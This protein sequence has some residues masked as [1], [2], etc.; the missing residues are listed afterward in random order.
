MWKDNSV[1]YVYLKR[2][3]Y[4]FSRRVPKDLKRYYKQSKITLSLRTK[5]LKVAKAKSASLATRLD[6]D[7]LTLR[8]RNNDNPLKRYMSENSNSSHEPSSA[9]LISKAKD[10]YVTAKG[11]SRPLTFAQ[12]VDRAISNLERRMKRISM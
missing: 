8:W 10:I 7:W 11:N 9:P 5:S 3:I 6:D 2:N 12:A 1:P 4:Y